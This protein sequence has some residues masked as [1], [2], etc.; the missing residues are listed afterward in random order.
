VSAAP[1]YAHTAAVDQAARPSR[2]NLV[3]VLVLVAALAVVTLWFVARPA[4]STAST[5]ARSC[6]TVVV[7]E[8]GSATCVTNTGRVVRVG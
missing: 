8:A 5:S 2:R 7:N 3:S 6:E 4:L 1:Q